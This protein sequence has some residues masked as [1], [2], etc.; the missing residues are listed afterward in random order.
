M[1]KVSLLKCESCGRLSVYSASG[2]RCECG[3]PFFAEEWMSREEACQAVGHDFTM[4][5]RS[6][7]VVSTRVLGANFVL[8]KRCDAK[9]PVAEYCKQRKQHTWAPG[10]P[11]PNTKSI[12]QVG[13]AWHRE[14][15]VRQKCLVCGVEEI[16]VDKRV[17]YS[18]H[19]SPGHTAG[20]NGVGGE[21]D[22]P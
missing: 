10:I 5:D 11:I 21:N 9:V 6:E 18:P 3:C 16:A 17:A 7:P 15:Q 13:S 1:P 14:E 19:D 8:C 20:R 12:R 2:Q 4:K 22:P